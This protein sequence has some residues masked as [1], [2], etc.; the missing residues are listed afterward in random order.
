M[1]EHFKYIRRDKLIFR[2]SILTLIFL[3]FS[4][5]YIIIF[6][7]KLPPLL[8]VF[9]QLPWGEERLSFTP[10]IFIPPITVGI[11]L[12][13]NLFISGFAYTRSPL[14]SRLLI[15]TSFITSLLNLLFIIRTVLLVI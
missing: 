2:L 8:P 6:Y 3:L 13:F 12:I 7:S 4:V 5:L 10:G 11:I 14:I 1:K 9:N 15:V